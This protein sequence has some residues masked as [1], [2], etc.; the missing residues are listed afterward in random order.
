MVY[1]RISWGIVPEFASGIELYRI[2]TL[3]IVTP[4]NAQSFKSEQGDDARSRPNSS[5]DSIA[6]R[7]KADLTE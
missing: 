6:D 3:L 2:G 5:R 4:A 1:Q 7:A